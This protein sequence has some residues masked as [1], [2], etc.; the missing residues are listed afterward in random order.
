MLPIMGSNALTTSSSIAT[1]LFGRSRQGVLGLLFS[2]TGARFYQ[3]QIVR[4]L[5]LGSGVIQRELQ[6][7]TRCGIL[8]RTVEGRQTYYQANPACPVFEE[9]RGLVRKTL[10]AADVLGRALEPLADR[11]RFAFLY[12]SLAA[13]TE[14]PGSDVDLMVV[15]DALS[16]EE[17]IAAVTDA[18]RL[19]SREVNPSVYPP[20]EFLSKLRERHHFITT[21]MQ[22]AKIVLIGD[23]GELAGLAE[24]RLAGVTQDLP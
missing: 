1:G 6:R 19:L 20:A 11:I 5:G 7:L 13:G 21:V 9:L 8:I 16:L 3:R 24:Q 18:E 2:R 10:G 22:S 12:G 23:E 4:A 17:V 14:R 15:A